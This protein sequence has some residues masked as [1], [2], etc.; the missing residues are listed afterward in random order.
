MPNVK[1]LE[2]HLTDKLSVI[3]DPLEAR[4]IAQLTLM[5]ILSF[6]KTQLSMNGLRELTVKQ[7]TSVEMVLEELLTG[8]PVQY[9]LGETEF[10]GY[11]I[12]VNQDVL[13]PRPET[14]ELVHWILADQKRNSNHNIQLLDICTG[15]G[16]IPVALKKH[17]PNA[18][19]SGLDISYDALKM[20]MQNAVLNK[21]EVH[22]YQQ[23]ILKSETNPHREFDVIVSNPPYV[24]HLEKEKMH[25]NVLDFE[26]HLAL[27]VE[28]GDPLL[29]YRTIAQFAAKT[30]K[31]GG[32]LYFEINEAYG[33]ETKLEMEKAG[34]VQI[35]IRKDLYDKDRM[36]KGVLS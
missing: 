27:F 5:H 16:C 33:A 34:F 35:E 29:F 25:K 12:K 21:A 18:K 22:F 19:V 28:D 32:L 3:Y 1:E 9:V 4:S 10:Y 2:S 26:P 36:V 30:L 20:A 8:K 7:I 24:R 17:L 11:K 31:S 14:E 6:S 23:D 15:S 13:I